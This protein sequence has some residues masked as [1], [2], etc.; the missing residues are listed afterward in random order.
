MA[1]SA[2]VRLPAATPAVGNTPGIPP[3]WLTGDGSTGD[4]VPAN[5]LPP[6]DIDDGSHPVG[7]KGV[8]DHV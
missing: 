1:P 6:T 4:P 3:G 5:G 8:A 7:T 2:G